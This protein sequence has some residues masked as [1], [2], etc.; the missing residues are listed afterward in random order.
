MPVSGAPAATHCGGFQ[1]MVHFAW[2]QNTDASLTTETKRMRSAGL[3]LGALLATAALLSSCST[4]TGP[5]P[6]GDAGPDSGECALDQPGQ[7]V[8]MGEWPL[9]NRSGSPVTIQSVR[10]PADASNMRMTKAWLVPIY[11]DRHGNTE[12]VGVGFPWPPT[13]KIVPSWNK[14]QPAAGG[15]IKP[16]QTLVLAFGVTRTSA[17]RDGRSGGPVIVYSAE[18]RTMTVQK[19]PVMVLAAGPCHM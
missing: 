12:E 7:W 9:E 19:N 14:R 1:H 10:L 11:I 18:G 8:T 13:L 2:A 16:G 4:M 5:G 15:V 3:M 6:L 17:T